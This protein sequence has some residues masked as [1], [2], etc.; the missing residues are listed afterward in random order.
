MTTKAA[1]VRQTVQLAIACVLV[2]LAL[3]RPASAQVTTGAV[4][5]TVEVGGATETVDVKGEAPVIQAQSGER[6]FT[7]E[8]EAVQNLPVQNR[9]FSSLAAFAPGMSNSGGTNPARLGSGGANNAT[10]DGIDL[11]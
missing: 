4:F 1:V 11:G 5:G 8:T 6:S 7:V 3:P 10:F 2:C 9:T